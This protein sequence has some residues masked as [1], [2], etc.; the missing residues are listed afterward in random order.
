[1]Q[2]V[3]LYAFTLS[4][5][6][7]IHNVTGGGLFGTEGT[8][9]LNAV[10]TATTL[11]NASMLN[12]SYGAVE[13]LVS[14]VFA[15]GM[16]RGH[17]M[18]VEEEEITD[19]EIE[20]TQVSALITRT[21]ALAQ[22]LRPCP[23]PAP[24]D[25]PRPSGTGPPARRP[26]PQAD[27]TLLV[28]NLPPTATDS[29]ELALWFTELGNVT[30]AVIALANRDL[31][32][33][34]PE[35]QK[36]LAALH[37]R[38]AVYFIARRRTESGWKRAILGGLGTLASTMLGR[39]ERAAGRHEGAPREPA[40]SS[41]IHRL[42]AAP[43]V[44]PVAACTPT[45][46]ARPPKLGAPSPTTEMLAASVGSRDASRPVVGAAVPF[47][48]AAGAGPSSFSCGAPLSGMAFAPRTR[49]AERGTAMIDSSS[50][51][52]DESGGGVSEA[53]HGCES[54]SNS[55]KGGSGGV[56]MYSGMHHRDQRLIVL[57]QTVLAASAALANHDIQTHNMVQQQRK[58]TGFA[59]VSFAS[60]YEA[61]MARE[62]LN[63]PGYSRL[64][65]G[66]RL[67]ARRAPEPSDVKWENL[68][69]PK[70]ER[71]CARLPANGVRPFGPAASALEFRALMHHAAR[72]LR[73]PSLASRCL[74]HT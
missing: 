41:H 40:A 20:A 33:R 74:T 37:E 70:R 56:G 53:S 25:A 66:R 57:R 31:L 34:M 61:D 68:E 67:S 50:S 27:Y 15:Y 26:P 49:V 21:S 29:H 9:F 12:S 11:G 39:R 64:F 19:N 17:A 51:Y 22:R 10:F 42:P 30:H 48:S 47:S 35:R 71:R 36:L 44:T 60:P 28:S 16:F 18:V 32:L 58:G 38:Q 14:A 62:A 8:S 2:T 1:M 43:G 46:A 65:Q 52:C 63:S 13:V 24:T 73:D 3:F 23:C 4:L 59:F 55:G 5:A 45:A 69:I 72:L 54:A 6:N 7:L